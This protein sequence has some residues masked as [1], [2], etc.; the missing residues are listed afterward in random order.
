MQ[1]FS[2]SAEVNNETKHSSEICIYH[3][4][5]AVPNNQWQLG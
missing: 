4:Q 3:L 1:D 2:L 5:E